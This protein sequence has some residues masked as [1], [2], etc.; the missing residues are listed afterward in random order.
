[1]KLKTS[2]LTGAALDWVV[3]KLEAERKLFTIYPQ[4]ITS[5]STNWLVGGPIIE[6]EGI[7][8]Y[9]LGDHEV[10]GWAAGPRPVEM[11]GPTP[12][13]AAMRYYV[14]LNS[15]DVEVDVPDELKE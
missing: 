12:L 7:A 4:Y 15:P 6:R 3:T 14:M 5:Y 2:E 11:H 8:L 1:M 10:N 13:V 9:P